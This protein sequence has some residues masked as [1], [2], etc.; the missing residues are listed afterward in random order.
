MAATLKNLPHGAVFLDQHVPRLEVK[1]G[2]NAGV[3]HFVA[4]SAILFV[5]C[6]GGTRSGFS[7]ADMRC[8][9]SSKPREVPSNPFCEG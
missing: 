8:F 5:V 1:G 4:L 6:N 9:I 2:K 7:Y 3:F